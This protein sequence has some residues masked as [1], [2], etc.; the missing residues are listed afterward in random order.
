MSPPFPPTHRRFL[1]ALAAVYAVWWLICARE[2]WMPTDWWLENVLILF[3][4]PFLLITGRWFVFSRTSYAITF[5]F[6]A[7]HTLGAHYTY[8]EVPYDAWFR[9]LT[10]IS[11]D[12][13]FGW[14]RNHFDRS[15][16]FLY[17]FLCTWPYREAF[18]YVA[19]PRQTYWSYLLTLCFSAATSTL[20]ELLEWLA[21]VL[22][23][24]ELG[25]AFLGTQGDIWDAHWDMLLA[26]GGA[27]LCFAVMLLI[28]AATGRDF[29]RE[30]G[31]SRRPVAASAP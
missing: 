20:Y 31:E 23:G 4:I 17:G 3:I 21:A 12:E 5:V 24:G 9:R 29:P 8:S 2:P 28:Q 16:H 26:A 25:M 18:Y 6:L 1:I 30:W 27:L 22:Y 11:I 10:G 19:T 7:L 15:V 14:E 13:T